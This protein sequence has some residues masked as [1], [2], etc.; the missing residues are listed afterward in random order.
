MFP[1]AKFV[2]VHR[3]PYIVFQSTDHAYRIG[4][5]WFSLQRPDLSDQ[6]SYIVGRYKAMYDAFFAEK[7][8]IPSGNYHEV[9]M[10]DIEREPIY[11]MRTLYDRLQL[12]DFASVEPAMRQ[13]IGSL[14]DYKKNEYPE[15]S[16][17]LRR[18]ISKVWEQCFDEWGYSRTGT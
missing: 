13:Y 6:T 5:R 1:D 15:L 12:S 3:N 16:P 11:Q 2:H 9:A 7:S 8:L 14:H 18:E 4:L 17:D 10:E